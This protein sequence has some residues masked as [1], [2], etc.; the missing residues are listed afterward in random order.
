[1]KILNMSEGLKVKLPKLKLP[2]LKISVF[3]EG[4]DKKMAMYKAIIL[5]LVFLVIV[6]FGYL[7]GEEIKDGSVEGVESVEAPV[8]VVEVGVDGVG[9]IVKE[10]DVVNG[11]EVVVEDGKA[12]YIYDYQP[13]SDQVE[14]IESF[15]FDVYKGKYTQEYFDLLV[16]N[17]SEEALRTVIAIS[18]A[19]TSMGK[20]TNRQSNFYG[21]FA[22]GNRQY[23]PDIET[24]SEVIC[25]GIE[26][27]YL[28]IGTSRS[29][30]VRY[31]GSYSTAWLNNYNWA[32]KKMEVK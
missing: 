14:I 23:D 24:M 1:M 25:K 28:G 29:K 18:V 19:E 16:D 22:G 32:Y 8:E 17:C 6:L 10:G 12:M 21:W 11:Q 4:A 30:V 5:V 31:V 27:N 15:V 13:K 9:N 7:Y 3:E 2:K 26:D 20:N